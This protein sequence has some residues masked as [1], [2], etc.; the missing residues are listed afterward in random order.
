MLPFLLNPLQGRDSLGLGSRTGHSGGTEFEQTSMQVALTSR[1][2]AR[3][4]SDPWGSVEVFGDGGVG[5][6]L[7]VYTAKHREE[8]GNYASPAELRDPH[9]DFSCKFFPQNRVTWPTVSL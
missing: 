9:R 4:L 3:I 6:G 2:S 5:Y 7:A 8:K 1:R